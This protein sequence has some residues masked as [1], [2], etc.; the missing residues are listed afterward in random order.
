[1]KIIKIVKITNWRF[2]NRVEVNCLGDLSGMIEE[3]P[4]NTILSGRCAYI[5]A[6]FDADGNGYE[7]TT[8][9][10]YNWEL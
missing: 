10:L 3:E 2:D 7:H 8:I 9:A 4:L 1:M 5:R 6:W